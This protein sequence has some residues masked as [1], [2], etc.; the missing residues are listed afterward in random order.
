MMKNR[1]KLFSI[2]A[3]IVLTICIGF[4][5]FIHYNTYKPMNEAISA[6]KKDNVEIQ[7]NVIIFNPAEEIKANLVFYQ[8][9]LVSTEAYAVLGQMFAERGVR[10][11]MPKMPLNLAIINSNAFDKI[12]KKYDDDKAW[13][14]GGHSLGGASASIYMANQSKEVKG[15]FF[16]GAY[17]SDQ[18][19]L[20]QLN[21]DVLS[22]MA[23]NDQ[24]VNQEN[25]NQTKGLLPQDTVY[26]EI[27][28]G[29]HS[30]Y[31][32]Y[33]LQRGDGS[34]TIKREEQHRMIADAIMKIIEKK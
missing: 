32:Y 6:M 24:I 15:I 20:S 22:V 2:V 23:T 16:L 21:I 34:S 33:G 25:F 1:V 7:E 11:F 4:A 19:D 14:I 17:P 10:T 13:Y 3:I 26:L 28:G 29:N 30:N 9:G 5:V 31:G 12:H 27:E 18:S 8:G